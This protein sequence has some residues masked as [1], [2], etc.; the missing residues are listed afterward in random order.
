MKLKLDYTNFRYE[1][2]DHK[3]YLGNIELPSVTKILSVISYYEF[4]DTNPMYKDRGTYIHK[5][6]EMF[7]KGTLD[8]K[9]LESDIQ[10][11]VRNWSN[12]LLD[13]KLLNAEV[14]IE[15]PLYSEKYFY[16]GRLDYIFFTEKAIIVPDVKS[17][18]KYKSDFYQL[19]GYYNLVMENLY[20]K[21]GTLK[22]DKHRP[23]RLLNVYTKTGKVQEHKFTK[24]DFNDFLCIK[25]A[26][27]IKNNL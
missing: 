7:L 24:K 5:C 19:L 23:I 1:D 25:R 27:E 11:Q 22:A 8:F 2:K 12:F 9:A 10:I 21:G 18:A 15:T 4:S 3:Y 26:Y 17:G 13:N 14:L 6:C 20:L 16:A